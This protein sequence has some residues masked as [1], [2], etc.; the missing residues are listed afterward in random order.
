MDSTWF[1]V[2]IA[3][4]AV[5][6]AVPFVNGAVVA[7]F[8][9]GSAPHGRPG[10]AAGLTALVISMGIG[11]VALIAIARLLPGRAPVIVVAFMLGVG[12]ARWRRKE[13]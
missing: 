4:C 13:L 3:A 12:L 10:I 1:I 8:A 9:R 7:T 2:A 5:G 6:C 11:S